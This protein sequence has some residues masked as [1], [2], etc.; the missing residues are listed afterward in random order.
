[1]TKGVSDFDLFDETYKGYYVAP[2]VKKLITTTDTTST[3]IIGWSKMYG[4]ARIV[5]LQSG[6]DSPTFQ[7]PAFRKLLLQSIDWVYEGIKK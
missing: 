4:K 7:N 1:M 6:H 2:D 3:P 5:T